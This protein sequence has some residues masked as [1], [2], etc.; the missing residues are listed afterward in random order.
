MQ[1]ISPANHRL[2]SFTPICAHPASSVRPQLLEK[3]SSQPA[4]RSPLL[5]PSPPSKPRTSDTKA[6]ARA[7]ELASQGAVHRLNGDNEAALDCLC[8][9]LQLDRTNTFAILN[10]CAITL[11]DIN[12]DNELK[13]MQ[14]VLRVDPANP[15]ALFCLATYHYE[16]LHTD[17]AV[18][19]LRRLITL[20]PSND[21]AHAGLALLL[22]HQE[23]YKG[24]VTHACKALTTNPRNS[25]AYWAVALMNFPGEAAIY[26]NCPPGPQASHCSTLWDILSTTS[27]WAY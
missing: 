20:N 16:H 26:E 8:E 23:N 10:R 21:A 17:E 25:A 14:W 27:L 6:A 1:S 12:A 11:G 9:A 22:I 18:S 24:A 2:T 5:G 7:A 3:A 15:F 13:A 19:T 4:T